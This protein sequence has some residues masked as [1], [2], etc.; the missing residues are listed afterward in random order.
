MMSF[1]GKK[2]FDTSLCFAA[3]HDEWVEMN[4]CNEI[5][6][7]VL[8][9]DTVDEQANRFPKIRPSMNVGNLPDQKLW[10]NCNG[11]GEILKIGQAVEAWTNDRQS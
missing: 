6:G 4:E 8:P 11:V 10:A 2:S 1:H 3:Q 9:S 7:T 5:S